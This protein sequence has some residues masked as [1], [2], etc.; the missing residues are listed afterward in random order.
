MLRIYSC[1]K[2]WIQSDSDIRFELDLLT[3]LHQ[4]LISVSHPLP[5]RDGDFLGV[6]SAPEGTR[7]FSLFSYADGKAVRSLTAKH[8]QVVGRRVAELHRT[9]DGFT[10]PHTRY[11]LDLELLIDRPLKLIG[12]CMGE[13]RRTD[14]HLLTELAEQLKDSVLDLPRSGASYGVIHAD[15]HEGNLHFIDDDECVFFDF[16]HCGYGWRAY[17]IAVSLTGESRENRDALLQ[18]YQSVRRLDEAELAAI[19]PFMK[20][21]QIWDVGDKLAMADMAGRRWI[22]DVLWDRLLAG[23]AE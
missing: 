14:F 4:Q 15:V 23:L 20:I 18:G 13:S 22:N 1:G 5:R 7:P 21:R 12:S 16:D 17:E 3:Y 10:T 9:A 2:Y 19:P 6:L 11:H 8:M